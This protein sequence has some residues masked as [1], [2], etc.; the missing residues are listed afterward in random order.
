MN[1][2]IV[3]Y[4]NLCLID[5]EFIIC[6]SKVDFCHFFCL[7]LLKCTIGFCLQGV[8]ITS[9]YKSD[10]NKQSCL[11]KS[12]SHLAKYRLLYSNCYYFCQQKYYFAHKFNFPDSFFSSKGV[13]IYR[14]LR[15]FLK[16]SLVIIYIL[17]FWLSRRFTKRRQYLLFKSDFIFVLNFCLGKE[18]TRAIV[19][20]LKCPKPKYRFCNHIINEKQSQEPC[21][22]I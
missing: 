2:A 5:A 14:Q 13:L 11:F 17:N 16:D 22:K 18:K 12:K 20:K 8:V 10:F 1:F 19:H 15:S 7:Y 6:N 3:I 9:K 21:T 4:L